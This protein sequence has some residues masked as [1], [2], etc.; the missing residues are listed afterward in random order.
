MTVAFFLDSDLVLP[1]P[2]SNSSIQTQIGVDDA[3]MVAQGKLKL[4]DIPNAV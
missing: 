3:L 1:N 4:V 2:P